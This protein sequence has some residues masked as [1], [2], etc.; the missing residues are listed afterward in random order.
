[1]VIDVRAIHPLKAYC[2][3]EVTPSGMMIIGMVC[4]I[5]LLIVSE[6]IAKTNGIV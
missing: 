1:M 6:P 3:M 2:P 5:S 4:L